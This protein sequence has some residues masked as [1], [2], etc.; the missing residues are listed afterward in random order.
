MQFI[1]DG[2]IA[3]GARPGFT[4]SLLAIDLASDAAFVLEDRL[5]A[6]QL[7]L[8]YECARAVFEFPGERQRAGPEGSPIVQLRGLRRLLSSRWPARSPRC[9]AS[10]ASR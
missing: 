8:N 5:L 10:T 4:L 6:F 3:L 1:G 2:Q 7:S 9:R